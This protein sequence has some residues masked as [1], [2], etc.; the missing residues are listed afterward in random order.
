MRPTKLTVILLLFV[1]VY[2]ITAF[3]STRAQEVFSVIDFEGIPEGAIVDSLFS[4]FG[5]SGEPIEGEVFVN[6]FSPKYGEGVNTA[7]IFD[8]TCQP[9]GTPADCTGNDSDLFNPDL[10]N[11]MIISEDRNGSDPDDGDLVGSMFEFEYTQLGDGDGIRI[12][13]I[14]VQDVEEEETEDARMFFY[15][16]GLDGEELF[17][18]DIPDTGN[19]NAQIVPV[20][21]DNV[22]AIKVDLQGSGMIDNIQLS[23][24]PTAVELLY[25]K[26]TKAQQGVVEL[27]WKTLAEIDNYGFNIY[28]APNNNLSMANVIAT[29]PT[30]GNG[31]FG[32][33]YSY[34]DTPGTE[35][36]YW[37]W[38]SDV[39]TYG[40]ETFHMP[41]IVR[42]IANHY[43]YLPISI[44]K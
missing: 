37:Y 42:V 35:G 6:G 12:D 17:S 16:G 22:D 24:V 7:M 32:H 19:G 28:R 8:A 11:T 5:I 25:F 3:G 15:E 10:G 26:V 4:G 13:S 30:A 21:V 14:T 27:D 38:L 41:A 33:T 18:V 39:D 29:V 2:A 1:F 40:K 20:G 23:S 36:P 34:T 44:S 9:G 43:N 31:P